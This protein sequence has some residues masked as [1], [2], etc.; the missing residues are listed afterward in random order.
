MQHL[1]YLGWNNFACVHFMYIVLRTLT[2]LRMTL[3][4]TG[5]SRIAQCKIFDAKKLYNI[6]LLN[7][8]IRNEIKCDLISVC[9]YIYFLV[10][11]LECFLRSLF[12]WFLTCK[13]DSLKFWN[14]YFIH[15]TAVW[16]Y[17]I[18]KRNSIEND[19]DINQF[20]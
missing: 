17:T 7:L 15:V 3:D 12:D 2:T 4:E 14:F 20:A 19:P 9:G 6:E 10:L 13:I 8:T 1:Q 18:F 16:N 5:Q 11:F